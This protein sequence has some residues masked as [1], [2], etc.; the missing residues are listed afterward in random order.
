MLPF[1]CAGIK[2]KLRDMQKEKVFFKNARGLKLCGILE[3]P[4]D[5]KAAVLLIPGYA[6]G[7]DE[8]ER[9]FVRYAAILNTAGFL[10]LRFDK[11]G[12]GESEGDFVDSTF[13]TELDDSLS[14]YNFLKGRLQNISVAGQSIGGLLA[15]ALASEAD[16]RAVVSS[17]APAAADKLWKELFTDEQVAELESKGKVRIPSDW[18]EKFG[19]KFLGMKY[20]REIQGF[21]IRL[22]AQKVRAPTL[23]V[24]GTK[25]DIVKVEHAKLLYDALRCK[26]RLEVIEGASHNFSP[27]QEK[28]FGLASAWFKKHL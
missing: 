10:T 14:A 18:K 6:S 8:W 7:K 21:D 9:F 20:F 24:Q 19:I 12:M 28:F 27:H 16:I 22:Y 5:A 11:A 13:E 25:D 4:K 1:K 17:A 26:K 3:G 15:I 23:V 2:T